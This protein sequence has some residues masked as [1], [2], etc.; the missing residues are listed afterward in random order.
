MQTNGAFEVLYGEQELQESLY[1]VIAN[2]A[3]GRAVVVEFNN[4]FINKVTV[5][6]ALSPHPHVLLCSRRKLQ[7][8]LRACSNTLLTCP[9]L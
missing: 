1:E 5:H 6:F 4:F 2:L 9:S 3:K 8:I 7:K